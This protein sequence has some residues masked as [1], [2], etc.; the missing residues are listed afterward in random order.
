MSYRS[1]LKQY[2]PGS[3]SPPRYPVFRREQG[4]DEEAEA[5]ERELNLM[6]RAADM[7]ARSAAKEAPKKSAIPRLPWQPPPPEAEKNNRF[8]RRQGLGEEVGAPA[9]PAVKKGRRRP[10]ARRSG[11]ATRRATLKG[12]K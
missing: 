10:N 1:S 11:A 6:R 12:G 2:S 9:S 7:A 4:K 5:I 8:M 3:R